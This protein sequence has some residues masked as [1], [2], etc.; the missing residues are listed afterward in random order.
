MAAD[1]RDIVP[2]LGGSRHSFDVEVDTIAGGHARSRAESWPASTTG[3]NTRARVP[4]GVVLARQFLAEGNS[5]QKHTPEASS[6]GGLTVNEA[7]VTMVINC[8][9]ISIVFFPKVMADLGIILAPLLCIVCA[10]TCHECG[11]MISTACTLVEETYGTPITT[12]EALASRASG[13]GIRRALLVTKNVAMLGYIIAFAQL[14]SD[15]VSTL[16]PGE[17]E[18]APV[19]LIRFFFVL[20][21]FGILGMVTDLKQIAAWSGVGLFAVVAKCL[22]VYTGGVVSASVLPRCTTLNATAAD[23]REYSLIPTVPL[24]DVVGTSGKYLAIFLFSFAVLATVPSVRGQLADKS[25]MHYVL[26][27]SFTIITLIDISVMAAGYYGF[28]TQSPENIIAGMA[29]SFPMIGLTAAAFMIVNI[30]VSFPLYI[31][32]VVSVFESSGSSE[33]HQP[34][35]WSNICFRLT[36][37][38]SLLG[39]GALLPYVIEVIGLVSAIFACCNNILYPVIFHIGARSQASVQPANPVMRFVKYVGSVSIGICVL[40]FGVQG[41]LNTLLKKMQGDRD[42][43]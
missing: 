13:P 28:G 12:Y 37:I 38:S 9:G 24:A 32:C 4:S 18:D 10:K 39:V 22:C 27:R 40:I 34:L 14:I 19:L 6:G 17:A 21:T 35:S 25:K 2:P 3:N 41:S 15:S 30:L 7:V 20:P 42:I 43:S 36:V 26:S 31:Y 8:V 33:L 23:C 5:G 29:D 1:E 11:V 16:L